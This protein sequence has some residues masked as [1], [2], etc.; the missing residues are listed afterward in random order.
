MNSAIVLKKM[1]KLVKSR[2][3]LREVQTSCDDLKRDTD[4]DVVN[5]LNDN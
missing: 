4:I 3:V 5:A 1:L 2:E